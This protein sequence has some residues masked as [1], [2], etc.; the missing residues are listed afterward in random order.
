MA[1]RTAGARALQLRTPLRRGGILSSPVLHFTPVSLG[2]AR[3]NFLLTPPSLVQFPQVVPSASSLLLAHSSAP[4][5][6]PSVVRGSEDGAPGKG[7]ERGKAAGGS[8]PRRPVSSGALEKSF[9]CQTSDHVALWRSPPVIL[10]T[11]RALTWGRDNHLLSW[12][13]GA[14][15]SGG[16]A[17]TLEGRSGRHR[18]PQDVSRGEERRAGFPGVGGIGRRGSRGW[19]RGSPRWGREGSGSRGSGRGKRD[20]RGWTGAGGGVPGA[21][22]RWKAGPRAGRAPWSGV[23]SGRSEGGAVL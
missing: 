6:W 23:G 19:G 17:R 20:P 12:P 4:G 2:G 21:S 9:L 14:S 3:T 22:G 15:R 8:V 16:T 11:P 5:P 13:R 10:S 7:Q 18:E 1:K